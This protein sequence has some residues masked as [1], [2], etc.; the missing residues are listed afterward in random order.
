MTIVPYIML[1]VFKLWRIAIFRDWLI[2]FLL[3]GWLFIYW[4]ICLGS[5]LPGKY[6]EA[7]R[8]SSSSSWKPEPSCIVLSIMLCRMVSGR[9]L[10]YA[11]LFR[12]NTTRLQI[13]S[14][15]IVFAGRHKISALW[16]GG[17]EK[18]NHEKE[19]HITSRL[20]AVCLGYGR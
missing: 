7:K 8:R 1:T 3:R 18:R 10:K 2:R 9:E 17:C 11:D 13:Y 5:P 16:R 19:K 15:L 20:A 4:R 12:S 14:V 6:W